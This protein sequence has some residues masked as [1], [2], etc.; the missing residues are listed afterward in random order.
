MCV[1]VCVCVCVCI[2]TGN[3]LEVQNIKSRIICHHIGVIFFF[4]K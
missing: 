4:N 2:H 3:V 1:C